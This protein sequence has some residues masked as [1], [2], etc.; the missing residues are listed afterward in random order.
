[1]NRK[2][3]YES[4][5]A[6]V[7]N[8]QILLP[9]YLKT[10]ASKILIKYHLTF[11]VSNTIIVTIFVRSRVDLIEHGS[12]PPVLLSDLNSRCFLSMAY[13]CCYQ[14]T[15]QTSKHYHFMVFSNWIIV[16]SVDGIAFWRTQLSTRACLVYLFRTRRDNVI[17][18]LSA[19]Y[20]INQKGIVEYVLLSSD[21][22][23]LQ[24]LQTFL[25][26][27]NIV[28]SDFAWRIWSPRRF[29][30]IIFWGLSGRKNKTGK[31]FL[32]RWPPV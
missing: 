2:N 32:V 16:A 1:M 18:A 30:M 10:N 31:I 6:Q 12:L 7:W 4:D 22:E 28:F 9:P 15:Q 24:S 14:Q 25:T 19:C 13:E 3:N 5:N 8:V 27:A 11:Q 21:G 23:K 17:T 26:H 29:V 20:D